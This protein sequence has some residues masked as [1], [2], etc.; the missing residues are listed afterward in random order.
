MNWT[1]NS[2]SCGSSNNGM[3]AFVARDYNFN[4]TSKK[5]VVLRC[6]D[7]GSLYPERFPAMESLPDAYNN[8]YTTPR[9]RLE[10]LRLLRRLVNLTRWQYML[11]WTPRYARPILDYGCGSGEFLSSLKDEGFDAGLYGTDLFKPTE[12][13]NMDF[14]WLPLDRFDEADR[15]YDWITMS[16]VIEHLASA[17]PVLT[18]LANV[19]S[20]NG[21]IWISTPNADSVLI[22][23]FKGF[24][25]DIDFPRHRQIYSKKALGELMKRAGL[26]VQ[27]LSAPRINVIIN[28]NSCAKN[29]WKCEELTTLAKVRVILV[30]GILMALHL[31]LPQRLRSREA[32]ELVLVGSPDCQSSTN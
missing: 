19:T 13:A 4:T 26:S 7:C 18:R 20:K 29:V 10:A 2:C 11:R 16:H 5:C 8:Y 15:R 27:F 6:L 22:K 24:A 28:F 1:G 3:H 21:S 12:A 25:R 14:E 32:P 30:A 31:V 9:H 23:Y 17:E